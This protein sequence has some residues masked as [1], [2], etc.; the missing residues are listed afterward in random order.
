MSACVGYQVDLICVLART[1]GKTGH[2]DIQPAQSYAS[3]VHVTH[4]RLDEA[5]AVSTPP[6]PISFVDVVLFSIDICTPAVL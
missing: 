6:T 3:V 5:R 2:L 1:A 4:G